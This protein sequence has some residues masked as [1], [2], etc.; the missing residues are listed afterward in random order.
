M[1]SQK[2]QRLF[3]RLPFSYLCDGDVGFCQFTVQ[4]RGALLGGDSLQRI[5]H[6]LNFILFKP[7]LALF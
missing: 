7:F 3:K 4:F 6:L 5:D 1:E 2:L